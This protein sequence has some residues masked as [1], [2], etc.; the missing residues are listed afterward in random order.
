MKKKI[1]AVFVM[2]AIMLTTMAG[3]A[4]A[5]TQKAETDLN[6]ETE[7]TAE[8]E[9]V[10]VEEPDREIDVSFDAYQRTGAV[11][12]FKK[13]DGSGNLTDGSYDAIGILAAE[14]ETIGSAL[15]HSGYAELM[16][17]LE[18]DTFEG[19]MEYVKVIGVDEFG[20]EETTY[21]IVADRFYTTEELLA[22]TVSANGGMY[23]AKWASIPVEDYFKPLEAWEGDVTT[24]GSFSLRAGGGTMLF[25]DASGYAYSFPTYTYWL[26]ET[27][28][29]LDAMV[30]EYGASMVAI[31]NYGA[32]FSG[33][34]LYEAD[35]VVWNDEP[36]EEE[37]ILSFPND[38]RDPDAGYDVL[39]NPVLVGE[40]I[41]TDQLYS[42]TAT[43]TNY[44]AVATW[45]GDATARSRFDLRG[46]GGNLVL[47][48]NQNVEYG[49]PTYTYWLDEDDA[50]SVTMGVDGSH[51]LV[52]MD[53]DDAV[54][55]GWTVYESD[56]TFWLR[57]PLEAEGVLWFPVDEENLVAGFDVLVNPVLY[58]EHVSTEEL[59]HI[60][61]S[62]TNYYAIA[63]WE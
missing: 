51:A 8:P 11:L 38:D 57:D 41:S 35:T 34:T 18:G 48:D 2:F 56:E 25:H 17:V 21:A 60:S 13:D 22:L 1:F 50:L 7:V 53:R 16:P 33:W 6:A 23:V 44:Y 5:P 49:V 30:S 28:T 31:H 37:G 20:S 32:M 59:C 54:F 36:V 10:V 26:E 45:D 14:G 12:T 55:T 40:D 24:S 9:E 58:G 4:S 27:E 19:W 62:N 42:M 39:V 61:C 47:L 3:C 46:N 29:L 63:N 15:E 43:D 52:G